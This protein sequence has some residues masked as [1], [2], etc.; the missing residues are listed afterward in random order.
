[1]ILL[2]AIKLIFRLLAVREESIL[3]IRE[4]GIQKRLTRWCGITQHTFVDAK[5]VKSVL[6]N[7]GFQLHQVIYYLAVVVDKSPTM[8]LPFEY[9]I[10]RLPVL[11]I[12]HRGART[13]LEATI[14]Q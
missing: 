11:K 14:M 13:L 10:P 1:M 6:I 5:R 8:F 4:L 9:L 3:V 12:V 7:E 2:F